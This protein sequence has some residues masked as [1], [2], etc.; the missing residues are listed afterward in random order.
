MGYAAKSCSVGYF[1]KDLKPLIE[2]CWDGD[3]K[4]RPTMSEVVKRLDLCLSE[5]GEFCVSCGDTLNS[6]NHEEV[7]CT[8]PLHA[9]KGVV[10]GKRKGFLFKVNFPS[11]A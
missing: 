10:R 2:E 9:C 11:A 5:L 8:S 7:S 4:N 6:S 1:P 3:M